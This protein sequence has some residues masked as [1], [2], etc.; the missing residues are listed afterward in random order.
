MDSFYDK[1][2]KG[3]KGEDFSDF[4]IKWPKL[5]P[6]IPRQS[7]LTI[8]D[9]G[10][11]DGRSVEEM[12]KLNADASFIG[13]D[14]SEIALEAAK[15][16]LPDLEVHHISDGGAFPLADNSVDFI[17]TSEVIEHVYDTRSAFE[18]LIRVLKPG[19]RMVMT[20]PHHGFIKNLL[21]LFWGFEKHFKPFGAHVR[22]F[23]PK[24]LVDSASSVGFKKVKLTTYGRFYPI[25]WC[26]VLVAEKPK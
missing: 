14:V 1:Y 6:F 8:L 7:G 25:P 21:I 4:P 17:Y 15:K 3:K 26:M 5:A 10:C 13:L 2:W 20:T 23:T 9:Y 11:G 16:R 19:G 18:E 12:T 22:F 24:S